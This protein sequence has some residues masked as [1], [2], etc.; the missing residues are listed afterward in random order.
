MDAARLATAQA[1]QYGTGARALRKLVSGEPRC[2]TSS[3]VKPS[4]LFA[5]AALTLASQADAFLVA[6]KQDVGLEEARYLAVREGNHTVIYVQALVADAAKGAFA[7]VVPVPK[8]AKGQEASDLAQKI[9]AQLD[10]QSGPRLVEYWEQD[11][12]EFHTSGPD[13]GLPE[14]SVIPSTQ[15][16]PPSAG[17][18]PVDATLVDAS[19]LKAALEK[20]GFVLPAGADLSGYTR[21]AIVRAKAGQRTA[22]ARVELDADKLTLPTRLLSL[23]AGATPPRIVVDVVGSQ[24]YEA[25]NRDNLAAPSN[26]EV[27]LGVKGATLPFHRQ[28][29]DS[30]FTAKP[31]AVV[32]EY[33]WSATSCSPCLAQP[34]FAGDLATLGFGAGASG[35]NEV[36][37]FTQGN[38][39]VKPDGPPALRTALMSCYAGAL[40]KNPGLS[41]EVD[42]AVEIDGGKVGKATPA[43]NLPPHPALL[44]CAEE[45][46]KATTF[47][48]SGKS[49][50]VKVQF[51]ALSRQYLS[52]VEVTHLRAVAQKD[53]KED[54][55][56]RAGAS[57]AG[58]GEIGPNGKPEIGVYASP[59]GNHFQSRYTVRHKWAGKPACVA[60][61]FGA[62]GKPPKGVRPATPPKGKASAKAAELVDGAMP[63]AD[64][65]AIDFPPPKETAPKPSPV[66]GPAPSPSAA[67]SAD[68][69]PSPASAPVPADEGAPKWVGYLA[70]CVCAAAL[71]QGTRKR[72]H[73]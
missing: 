27:K 36:M 8:E 49:G 7:L 21:F 5:L 38:V 53:A 34:L 63:T 72:A 62:W 23:H 9:L 13:D 41:G 60:P 30:L 14:M 1:F 66:P 37:I 44:A 10:V 26:V 3:E 56:L 22:T 29:V 18:A 45:S 48:G 33:A 42:L 67:P 6:G 70:L 58:G 71:W 24:R 25:A 47:D 40:A 64:G 2:A 16:P 11:P 59:K 35:Q 19:E 55:E 65:L 32:T 17:P 12:C 50:N 61:Q 54:L 4:L 31:D 28:L 51:S 39:A 52:T 15:P 20:D 43:V 73:V 69:P 68:A 57:I 46:V